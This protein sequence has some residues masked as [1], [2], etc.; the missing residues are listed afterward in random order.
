MI[1]SNYH[2]DVKENCPDTRNTKVIPLVNEL[3]NLGSKV[4]VYDPWIN[5]DDFKNFPDINLISSLD[6]KKYDGI[7]LA[8]SHDEFKKLKVD[9]LKNLKKEGGIVFDLKH[10][11][12]KEISNLRL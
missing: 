11:L 4:D 5:T 2:Q 10:I 3:Q 6:N 9:D 1:L 12:P 7:I 8:V